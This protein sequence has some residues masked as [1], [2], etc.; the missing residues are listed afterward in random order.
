[1]LKKQKQKHN[2]LLCKMEA[3]IIAWQ[4]QGFYI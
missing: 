3:M 2:F 1:M 4:V